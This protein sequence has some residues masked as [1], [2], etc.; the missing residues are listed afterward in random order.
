VSTALSLFWI[1]IFAFVVFGGLARAEHRF[2]SR[3][4]AYTGARGRVAVASIA[5]GWCGIVTVMAWSLVR[6]PGSRELDTR[7]QPAPVALAWVGSGL[8]AAG[9]VGV[10]GALVGAP[11]MDPTGAPRPAERPR[12]LE[13]RTGLATLLAMLVLTDVPLIVASATAT[14]SRLRTAPLLL[15]VIFTTFTVWTAWGLRDELTAE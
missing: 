3:P 8:I 1:A 11:L 7:T 2:V 10:L 6:F 12:R 5:A 9:T 13:H 15:V 14:H 4:R